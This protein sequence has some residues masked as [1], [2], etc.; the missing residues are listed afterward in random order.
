MT[1]LKRLIAL[2]VVI[3]APLA[4]AATA[5]ANT[6]EKAPFTF[7][8]GPEDTGIT[9]GSGTAAFDVYDSAT[10]TRNDKNVFDNDGNFIRTLRHETSVGRLTNPLTG[11]SLDYTAQMNTE[12]VLG[13]AQGDILTSR[14]EMNVTAAGQ[15]VVLQNA[16]L[17]IDMLGPESETFIERGPKEELDYFLQGDAALVQK[18]CGA[19]GP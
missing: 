13:T 17:L 7:S 15:G 6:I 18:L 1:K 11:T 3:A 19:L 9:C 10:V 4:F 14:G 16:G 5:T 2:V 8:Y 12:F